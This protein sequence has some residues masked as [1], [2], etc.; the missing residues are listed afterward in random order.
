MIASLNLTLQILVTQVA[1]APRQDSRQKHIES[2]NQGLPNDQ[3]IRQP[4][5]S[6]LHY[7][8]M[9]DNASWASFHKWSEQLD[10]GPDPCC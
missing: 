8:R 4:R 2:W 7:D 6:S 5:V 1:S 10:P 9:P 3:T